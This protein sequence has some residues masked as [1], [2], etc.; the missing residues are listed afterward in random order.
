MHF[1]LL[2]IRPELPDMWSGLTPDNQVRA[3]LP[4]MSDTVWLYSALLSSLQ[5]LTSKD[6]PSLQ[7]CGPSCKSEKVGLFWPGLCCYHH[8]LPVVRTGLWLHYTVGTVTNTISHHF[9][10]NRF[11]TGCWTDLNT[12]SLSSSS[13]HSTGWPDIRILSDDWSIIQ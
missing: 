3:R 11:L 6:H 10:H 4:L 13:T 7:S 2:N 8:L 1:T 5:Q 12:S 9:H